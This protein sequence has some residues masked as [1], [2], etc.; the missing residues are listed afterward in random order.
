MDT[1]VLGQAVVI[2]RESSGYWAVN[3][4]MHEGPDRGKVCK[5][6]LRVIDF[7]PGSPVPGAEGEVFYVS[8]PSVDVGLVVMQLSG[9]RRVTA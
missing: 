5:Y 3:V 2:G 9:H 8:T 6:Y 1:Q 4:T 7:Y